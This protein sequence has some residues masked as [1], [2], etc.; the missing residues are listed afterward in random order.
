ML[1]TVEVGKR[2]VADYEATAGRETVERLKEL[3]EPLCA[4]KLLF[5]LRNP[6]EG[7]SLGRGSCSRA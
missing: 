2:S 1:E 5:L 7:R 3:A 6:E 4:G